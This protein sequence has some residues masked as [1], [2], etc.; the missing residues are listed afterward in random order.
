MRSLL[1]VVAALCGSCADDTLPLTDGSV[2][3][4]ASASND[5][6]A[7]A[8][9]GLPPDADTPSDTGV[10]FVGPRIFV[11]AQE[12]SAALAAEPGGV[13]GLCDNLAAAAGLPG[14]WNIWISDGTATA[15]ER[16]LGDGPWVD[17]AGAVV[18]PDRAAFASGPPAT[19][20][21][22]DERGQTV[23]FRPVWTGTSGDG[24]PTG[25]DCLSWTSSVAA[26]RGTVGAVGE[27]TVEWTRRSTGFPCDG[28]GHVY[29]FEVGGP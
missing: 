5:A 13:D 4:G 29:C 28:R 27:G 14:R 1:V 15:N 10:P 18:F 21:R 7:V 25:N 2:D 22:L 20:L 9:A 11:S 12:F 16:V 8:E 26:S 6:G 23:T 17:M 19:R 24:T 3:S